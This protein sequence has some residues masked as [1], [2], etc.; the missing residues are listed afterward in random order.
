MSDP[1]AFIV[2][3][4]ADRLAALISDPWAKMGKLKQLISAFARPVVGAWA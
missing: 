3:N 1:K 4:L 2:A